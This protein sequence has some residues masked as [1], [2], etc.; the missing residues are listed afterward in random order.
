[1]CREVI[2]GKA[3]SK[4]ELI[5]LSNNTMT[6]RIIE[7]SNDIECQLL[8]K[9]KSSPYYSMQLDESTDLTNIAVANVFPSL[10]VFFVNGNTAFVFFD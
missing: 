9:M 2:G 4:L 3:A 6:R 1:M 7:M 5:P 10:I 8:E